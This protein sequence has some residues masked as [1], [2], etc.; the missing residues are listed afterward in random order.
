ML[1]LFK[2][3]KQDETPTIVDLTP[4]TTPQPPLDY[5][6]N[7]FSNR[8]E[9]LSLR[10]YQLK[11]LRN[12][13][14]ATKLNQYVKM[15]I[16]ASP[17]AGKSFMSIAYIDWYLSV[18]PHAKILVI[19]HG[20]KILRRQWI[21]YCKIAKPNF[22]YE[23]IT[24]D[25][26]NFTDADVFVAIPNTIHKLNLQQFDLIVVDEAHEFYHA[27]MVQNI[28]AKAKPKHQL[29]LTGTP[30]VFVKENKQCL[31]K[32]QKLEYLIQF[33]SYFELLK[34][35]LVSNIIM[36]LCTS[37]YKHTKIDYNDNHRLK[38]TISFSNN[39]TTQT[40][41]DLLSQFL[42]KK[43][44][45]KYRNDPEMFAKITNNS[46]SIEKMLS[47]LTKKD[48]GK[49][50]I[51]CASIEQA[52]QAYTHFVINDY[53]PAISV[54]K[55]V[56]NTFI[57]NN[58]EINTV[59]YDD[60][61]EL[62]RFEENL[63]DDDID[64]NLS[65]Y[66]KKAD[67]KFNK[68]KLELE[69]S[70]MLQSDID[71]K[72]RDCQ[73]MSDEQFE[74]RRLELEHGSNFLIV[75]DRGSLG[76]DNV[77]MYNVIDISASMNVRD[78]LQLVLRLGRVDPDVPYDEQHKMFFKV[79]SKE[80]SDYAEL[81]MSTVLTLCNEEYLSRYTGGKISQNALVYQKTNPT[82]NKKQTQT[83]FS[84]AREHNIEFNMS[85]FSQ[86]L[87][88][89][90][91]FQGAGYCFTSFVNAEKLV[92]GIL[93][94]YDNILQ[95]CIDENIG[96]LNDFKKY[97]KEWDY[98]RKTSLTQKLCDDM[99]W[100][101]NFIS[102]DD[103]WNRKFQELIK[104]LK[105]HKN[106]YPTRKT[107][108][109][110]D[111]WLN[112]QKER[113]KKGLLEN[114]RMVKLNSLPNFIWS[115]VLDNEWL[116]SFKEV[117]SIILN[118][119]KYPNKK[120]HKILVTWCATQRYYKDDLSDDRFELLNSLPNFFK[121]Y[122]DI[123]TDNLNCFISFLASNGTNDNIYPTRLTNTPLSEWAKE[124]ANQIRNK[125][126]SEYR[127]NLLK[128]LPDNMNTAYGCFKGFKH[129]INS[130]YENES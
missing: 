49:T 101:N 86:L 32:K 43:L 106:Q 64:R 50:M 14:I 53:L 126:I 108:K 13:I 117:Q 22:K 1:K 104:H 5:I 17:A 129:L 127:L 61:T 51:V 78:L 72:L 48:I 15:L 68:L 105:N 36:E 102:D 38:E 107:N 94:N 91:V 81:V 39:E 62:G 83:A 66:Q 33:V 44:I 93:S 52:K 76:Y 79:V 69:N 84:F 28:I 111:F 120:N 100:I 123:W 6:E 26:K 2:T 42:N 97:I 109:Q 114:Y 20:R 11:I 45:S 60:D 47:M 80:M 121:S 4:A 34:M 125:K 115:N 89:K 59:I 25:S 29:L 112:K 113:Y 96:N 63:T 124:Q 71:Q 7:W 119:G 56:E 40:L 82:T 65:K 10:E 12:L 87:H 27:D 41:S 128:T 88:T 37:T 130:I 24:M 110:L 23:E 85:L 35:K 58:K 116:E 74:Q 99:D 9:N 103:I 73:N 77:K 18:F 46:F 122:D 21:N 55:T 3:K 70:N 19:T 57:K 95:L 54:S 118:T 90:D 8:K 67:A 30:D 75:V 31:D 92:S 16:A 98:I